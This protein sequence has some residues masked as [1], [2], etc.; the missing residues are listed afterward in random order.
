M[1]GREGLVS[2]VVAAILPADRVDGSGTQV[3][4]PGGLG[5]GLANLPS[6]LARTPAG[7]MTDKDEGRARVLTDRRRLGSRQVDVFQDRVQGAAGGRSL[8]LVR[9]RPTQRTLAIGG[10]IG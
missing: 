2:Q 4:T 3:G 6:Q 5:D 7:G 10:E 8:I 9:A 1:N